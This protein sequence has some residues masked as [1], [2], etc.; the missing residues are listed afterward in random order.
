MFLDQADTFGANGKKWGASWSYNQS[1]PVSRLHIE[2]TRLQV[3]GIQHQQCGWAYG[4]AKELWIRIFGSNQFLRLIVEQ[5]R[6]TL[7]LLNFWWPWCVEQGS[8][9][10]IFEGVET[11]GG[12]HC[13]QA[14]A[15]GVAVAVACGLQKHL[16]FV[17]GP[18]HAAPVA[19]AAASM[20][21]APP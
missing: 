20:M 18:R 15:V 1:F 13:I 10:N 4:G 9:H 3:T 8:L 6:P 17:P 19:A 14:I 21:M 5:L 12:S 11:L 7:R 16:N 2:Q